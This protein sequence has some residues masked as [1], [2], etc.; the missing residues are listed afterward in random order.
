MD[1]LAVQGEEAAT[2]GNIKEMCDEKNIWQLWT[3]Q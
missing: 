2:K 1:E 3:M